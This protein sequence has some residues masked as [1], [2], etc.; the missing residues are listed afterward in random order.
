MSIA[1]IRC[2]HAHFILHCHCNLND[3]VG[4][5]KKNKLAF[6]ALLNL[7][8]KVFVMNNQSVEYMRSIEFENVVN[9]PNCIS[10]RGNSSLIARESS[11]SILDV[12]FIGRQTFEKGIDV[13]I[14]VATKA[15]TNNDNIIFHIVGDDNEYM[16][17]FTSLPK[18]IVIHGRKEHSETLSLLRNS[19]I[20]LFPSRTE[21]FPYVVLEAMMYGVPIIASRV[22]AIDDMLS[23]TGAIVIDNFEAECY[24][25]S[26]QKMKD[27]EARRKVMTNER[28]RYEMMYTPEVVSERIIN[29]YNELIRGNAI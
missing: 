25:D 24:Y 12:I 7:V 14:D 26:L 2:K 13:V 16:A 11:K 17:Q 18:N 21:G 15:K 5:K 27:F 8:D 20:M 23:G 19:D 29:Q 9:I 22:G 28:K 3:Y 4:E 6:K 10:E 1:K